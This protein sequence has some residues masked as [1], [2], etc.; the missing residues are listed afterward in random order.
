LIQTVNFN[1]PLLKKTNPRSKNLAR[2]FSRVSKRKS[3][4]KR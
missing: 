3:L 2:K 1:W 4:K